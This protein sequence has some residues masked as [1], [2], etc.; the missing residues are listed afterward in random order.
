MV[1]LPCLLCSL[2]AGVAQRSPDTSGDAPTDGLFELALEG[3]HRQR[4]E[5]VRFR[6]GDDPRELLLPSCLESRGDSQ[7]TVT[8]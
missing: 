5:Q 8:T 2:R 4:Y 3:E 7:C 6:G 1:Y